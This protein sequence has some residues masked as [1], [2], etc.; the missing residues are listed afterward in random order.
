MPRWKPPRSLTCR[1][2]RIPRTFA[3]HLVGADVRADVCFTLPH[4]AA[5]GIGSVGGASTHA[6]F[7]YRVAETLLRCGPFEGNALLRDLTTEQVEQVALGLVDETARLDDLTARVARMLG[8]N[9]RF[10]LDDSNDRIGRYD[11]YTADIW[12][13]T[14]PLADQLGTVWS[15]GIDRA[16]DLVLAVGSRGGA[17][18][19]WG[20]SK[21]D[22]AAALTLELAAF[23]LADERSPGKET[24]WLRRAAD[25]AVT[26]MAGFD[27]DGI[28]TAHVRRAQ[29]GYRGPERRLQLTFDLLGKIAW[30]AGA[31]GTVHPDLPA[32]GMVEAYPEADRWLVF[33]D[34]RPAGVW[35]HR[36]P[37]A[38]FVVPFVGATRPDVG[39]GQSTGSGRSR[40][41]AG[42]DA[43][44]APHRHRRRPSHR[45]TGPDRARRRGVVRT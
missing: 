37:G 8:S 39:T 20:R 26:L 25:A 18:V 43:D 15:D 34:D 1:A 31:L 5:A 19:P 17:A 30:A 16:L 36:S 42:P 21:G 10:A 6:F 40:A 13:F 14:E 27:A 38:S 12:L 23:A 35:T 7:S 11:I 24:I 22:L 45:E 29:D 41:V 4:L 32:A 2:W 33:E 44:P 3:G 28:T 9:P